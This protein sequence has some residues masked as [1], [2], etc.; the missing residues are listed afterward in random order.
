MYGKLI[1]VV[2]LQENN[3]RIDVS[4]LSAGVYFIKMDSAKGTITKKFIKK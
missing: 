3:A 1:Q 2:K 4:H